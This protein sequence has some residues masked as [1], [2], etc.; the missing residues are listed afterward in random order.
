MLSGFDWPDYGF[1]YVT[2]QPNFAFNP[3]DTLRFLQVNNDI[4]KYN[5]DGAE[6]ELWRQKNYL[7]DEIK[8][9][10]F[11]RMHKLLRFK[12]ARC[13]FTSPPHIYGSTIAPHF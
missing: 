2:E 3:V 6:M 9:R 13:A 1:D 12:R 8:K 5:I 11:I 10:R 7:F 4:K